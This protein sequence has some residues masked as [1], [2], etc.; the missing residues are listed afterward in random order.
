MVVLRRK[1]LEFLR[2]QVSDAAELFV[3]EGISSFLF[4][5]PFRRP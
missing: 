2:Y 4:E 3:A 5:K 1:L